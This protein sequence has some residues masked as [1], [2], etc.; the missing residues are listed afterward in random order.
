MRE[1]LIGE[2]KNGSRQMSIDVFCIIQGIELHNEN[3]K[4]VEVYDN[5]PEEEIYDA[6]IIKDGIRHEINNIK[7]DDTCIKFNTDVFEDL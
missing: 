6:V 1:N 2:Y 7:V 5:N 4:V 3:V